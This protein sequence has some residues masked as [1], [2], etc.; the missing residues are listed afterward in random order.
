MRDSCEGCE[1]DSL[2]RKYYVHGTKA[3]TYKKE[4]NFRD[5]VDESENFAA[6]YA[7]RARETGCL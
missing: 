1:L 2:N 5:V 7:N 4:A 6:A 3:Q